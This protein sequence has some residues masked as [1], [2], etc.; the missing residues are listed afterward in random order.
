MKAALFFI[1][2]ALLQLGVP[3]QQ[4]LTGSIEGI[5]PGVGNRRVP[6]AERQ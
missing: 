4:G 6:G 5:V 3:A 1:A 2:A